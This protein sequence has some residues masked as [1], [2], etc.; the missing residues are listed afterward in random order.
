MRK[1]LLGLVVLSSGLLHGCATVQVEGKPQE[2]II[3]VE[4]VEKNT[5][6]V[7]ANSWMVDA[8]NDRESVVQF[9]DKESGTVKGRY[10]LRKGDSPAGFHYAT[11]DV[12][13]KDEVTKITVTPNPYTY[14]KGN[15]R[16][17]K[18]EQMEKDINKLF[19]SF[20]SSIKTA[21]EK[22]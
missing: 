5:L 20:E 13:V 3:E 14:G 2:R 19:N 4:G 1:F 12:R 7:R 15:P 11:I 10:V 8:F 16:A 18:K 21:E 6:Y 22:W 9:T 17:Y